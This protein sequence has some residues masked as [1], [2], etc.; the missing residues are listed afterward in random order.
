LK[1]IMEYKSLWAKYI[2]K[3]LMVRIHI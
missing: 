3:G 2:F 1:K